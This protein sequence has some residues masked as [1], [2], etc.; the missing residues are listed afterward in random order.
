[1]GYSY[2]RRIMDGPSRTVTRFREDKGGQENIDC[3]YMI[4]VTSS[5][6]NGTVTT[7][8][9]ES[10]LWRDYNENG[11][12][13]EGLGNVLIVKCGLYLKCYIACIHYLF[14]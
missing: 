6:G 10:D 3:A 7:C 8:R 4:D 13:R 11:F 5:R 1:M 14:S 9:R 2:R 12:V